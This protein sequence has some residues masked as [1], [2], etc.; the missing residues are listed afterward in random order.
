VHLGGIDTLILN[1]IVGYW[2]NWGLAG[3]P[4]LLRNIIAVNTLSYI[5]IASNAL[6]FL[7]QS[8]GTIAVVSSLAGVIGLPKVAPYSA[9]KHALRKHPV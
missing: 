7:T 5:Y 3:Q 8:N 4:A 1:H 9:S 2:G 6:P